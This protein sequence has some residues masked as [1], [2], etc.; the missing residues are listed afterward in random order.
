MVSDFLYRELNRAH[1][2]M[3]RV[4]FD[5]QEAKGEQVDLENEVELQHI[6]INELMGDLQDARKEYQEL[7]FYFDVWSSG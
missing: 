7:K 1:S 6:K 2:N 4:E 3:R 5:Y